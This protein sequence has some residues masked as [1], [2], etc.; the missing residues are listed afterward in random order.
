MVIDYQASL[1]STAVELF[2]FDEVLWVFVVRPG[3]PSPHVESEVAVHRCSTVA[4]PRSSR[5]STDTTGRPL[6][7]Q[8][9][10]PGL[11]PLGA[12]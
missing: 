6:V 7:F 4:L 10:V 11:C 9:T 2:W 5:A 12:A 3:S 8:A 1:G